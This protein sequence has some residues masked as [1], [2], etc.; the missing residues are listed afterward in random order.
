[1]LISLYKIRSKKSKRCLR[2][3]TICVS[4]C[5]FRARESASLFIPRLPGVG[6]TKLRKTEI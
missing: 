1:M 3:A 2:I 4:I 5:E 6:V